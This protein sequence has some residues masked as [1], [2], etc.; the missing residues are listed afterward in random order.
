MPDGFGVDT[1]E[2]AAHA[3]AV[4]QVAEALNQAFS[5]AEQVTLGVQAYGLICGPLFV[6]MVLAV[7][8]P[9]LV[10]LGMAK[11]AMSSAS[12]GLTKTVAHY[13]KVDQTHAKNM[14]SVA[15]D[16]P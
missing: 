10:T 1:A 9:G 14:S 8:A 6:P 13:Q 7:S 12:S 16:L 11:Q 15:K 4:D 3:K 2:L 5:A